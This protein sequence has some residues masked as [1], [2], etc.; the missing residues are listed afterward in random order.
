MYFPR[1]WGY[2]ASF[3]LFQQQSNKTV[4]QSFPIKLSLTFIDIFFYEFIK[5]I[6]PGSFKPFYWNPRIIKTLQ[7]SLLVACPNNNTV[8]NQP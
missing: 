8:V 5:T 1:V 3:P 2:G 4:W 6:V 7:T